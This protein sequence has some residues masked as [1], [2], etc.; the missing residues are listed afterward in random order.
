MTDIKYDAAQFPEYLQIYYK[1]LFPYGPYYKWLTYGLSPQRYFALREFSF[2]LQDDVYI[3]YQSFNDQ[4]E[5][6]K[7]IQRKNPC[8]IDIGAVFN[9]KPRD[10]KMIGQGGFQ[11][12]EKEL[13]FDIDLTDY[14]EVRFCC[15]GSDICSKCWPFMSVTV[16]VLDR[17]LRDDF[18]FLH[19][20]WVY[21]GRRGIHCWV[22]D[23]AARKLSQEARTAVVEYLS[24]VKG[25]QDQAKK[26]V[27]KDTLHPF[28]QKSVEVVRPY[29]SSLALGDQDILGSDE[30]AGTVLALIPDEALRKELEEL[31]FNH[32]RGPKD[33]A[34]RWEVLSQK[35]KDK[36]SR[37]QK[38]KTKLLEEIMLQYIYPRLDVNVSTGVN[39]LLKS[40]FCVHPKT[41]RVCIP[42][43]P[44]KVDQFSPESAPIISDVIDDLDNV[45]ESRAV[46]EMEVD[47]EDKENAAAKPT[48]TTATTATTSTTAGAA[49]KRRAR[50]YNK[51]RLR[52]ALVVF[53]D[54]LEKLSASWKGK[55]IEES[56]RTGFINF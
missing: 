36:L 43:D 24:L 23:E 39:H 19:L 56:D 28:I 10:H 33:S 49:G 46:E 30:K 8:K 12:T 22:C 15:Q 3:R 55:Q 54:F 4:Q 45:K 26:V 44:S 42:I 1:R 6:E 34:S 17:A 47:S 53:E 5:M 7:E 20:L 9:H 14:D 37:G 41:G 18:G 50:D 31:F 38:W 51:T 2:T 11:A 25:G 16:K 13:V 48:S 35:Y 27:L 21:S 29:F 40:P 52:P 32:P